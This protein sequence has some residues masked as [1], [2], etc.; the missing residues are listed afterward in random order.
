MDNYVYCMSLQKGWKNV[1]A[2]LTVFRRRY[3]D[4]IDNVDDMPSALEVGVPTLHYVHENDKIDVGTETKRTLTSIP[5]W[6]P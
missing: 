5:Y 1:L 4:T 2:M 6:V 3:R